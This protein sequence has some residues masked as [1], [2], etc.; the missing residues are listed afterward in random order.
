MLKEAKLLTDFWVEA[1]ETDAYLRNRTATGPLIDGK[2]TTPK[3]AFTGQ[4]PSID[5]V[6]VWGCKVYSYV[7]PKSLPVGSRHDKFMDRARVGVFMGY[8][9]ETEKQ[10]RLWAP[11]LGRIIRS[12]AMRFSESEK[13]GD[14]DL[15]L[16]VKASSNAVPQRRPVGRPRKILFAPELVIEE[17]ESTPG[18]GEEVDSEADYEPD[19]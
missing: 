4:K 12:H 11:D 6:R 8:V 17:R 1:A 19:V 5:H 7:D 18:A 16:K 9:D 13:G 14:V 2:P 3:E 15:K 10:Y